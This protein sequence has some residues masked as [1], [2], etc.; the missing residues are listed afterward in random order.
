MPSTKGHGPKIVVLYACVSTD[1]Q[2]RSGFSLVQQLQA[3]RAYWERAGYE[4]LE[5]VADPR[6]AELPW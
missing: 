5:E 1:E 4:G 3:L 2:A 6:R